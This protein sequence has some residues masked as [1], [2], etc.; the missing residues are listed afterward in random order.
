MLLRGE[1]DVKG[2]SDL[3]TDVSGVDADLRG[4]RCARGLRMNPAASGPNPVLLGRTT[5]T[6][7]FI[8]VS[9]PSVRVGEG[10]PAGVAPWTTE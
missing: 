2:V 10:L 3:P 6:S 8:I 1:A 4:R 9:D 5:A 7:A